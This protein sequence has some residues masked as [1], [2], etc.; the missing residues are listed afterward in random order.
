MPRDK[1]AQKNLVLP[2]PL[3]DC[4]ELLERFSACCDMALQTMLSCLSD[5]LE[6]DRA[7]RFENSHRIGEPSDCGLLLVSQPC[8]SKLTDVT[9]STHTDTGSLTLLFCEQWA[10]QIELPETKQWAFVEPKPG[11]ALI[12]VAD[13]VQSLSGNRLYSCRHRVTQPIDGFQKRYFAVYYLRPEKALT[14]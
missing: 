5:A 4:S 11:H 2:D 14:S 13:K 7:N 3:R 9:D 6:L 12:N 10:V 1:M 8:K